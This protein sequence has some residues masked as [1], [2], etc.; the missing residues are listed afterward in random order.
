MEVIMNRMSRD[1]LGPMVCA[2]ILFL[3][4]PSARADDT[5]AA[6]EA[7]V[8]EM[9]AIANR[10]DSKAIAELYTTD[11]QFLPEGGDAIKGRAAIAKYFQGGFDAG[12]GNI[13][14]KTLEVYSYGASA[15]EVGEYDWGNKEGV[16][17]DHGKYIVVYRR[18]GG[19]WMLHRD[20]STSSVPPK[21]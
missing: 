3:S 15:T 12:F 18:V 7:V 17:V 11:A 20:M 2:A 8:A 10:G 4:T 5:R 21:K 13:R 9:Q 14:F 1:R 16:S 19:R 6:I